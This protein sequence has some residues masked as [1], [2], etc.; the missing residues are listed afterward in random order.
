MIRL[1]LFCL[2][3]V[4]TFSVVHAELKFASLFSD[5][6]VI[7]R[8]SRVPVWGFAEPLTEVAVQGSW[9]K[10][11][12]KAISDS[13]GTWKVYI[14][15]PPAGGPFSIRCKGKSSK[16]EIR[17]VLSGEVWLCA[18]QS[19]MEMTVRG[20]LNQ[21]VLHAN[22]ILMNAENDQIRLMRIARNAQLIPQ[23]TCNGQW[24]AASSVSI[25]YFSLVGYL[26]AK[27]L[28]EQLKVPVGIVE[29]SWGGSAIQ[30]WMSRKCLESMDIPVP[31]D[32]HNFKVHRR[33]PSSLYNGMIAPVAGFGIR[34]FLWYQGESNVGNPD[35]Y[36]RLLPEMV[37][38]WRKSWNNDTLPFYYV[39]VAPYDYPNGNGALLRE[40][41]LK[42]SKDIPY[43]GMAVITDAGIEKCIHPSDKSIVAKRLIYWAMNRTYGKRAIACDFPEIESYTVKD[44]KMTLLFKNAP[45][46]LTS[47]NKPITLFEVAGEDKIF[48]PANAEIGKQKGIV[49]W[50]DKV[51]HPVAVRYGFKSWIE[52]ELY[53]TE[54]IPVPSFRTDN[55]VVE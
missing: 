53:S 43:S 29:T 8:D 12:Y 47:Y 42:A 6:M 25:R 15:T 26:F 51:E 30:P 41:Q 55:W 18:G 37:K 36:R 9:S 7:Q 14:E 16:A 27:T 39:Q 17:N 44:G 38:D 2:A 13:T 4:I 19:N 3:N 34:G 10:R 31:D 33:A 45:N 48:Y 52:G 1:I 23:D 11:W 20:S 50:S 54:G 21:P 24:K 35:L 40:A 28:H 22:D 49:V 32:F 46:G 5:N